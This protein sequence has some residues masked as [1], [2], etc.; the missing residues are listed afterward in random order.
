[1]KQVGT[2]KPYVWDWFYFGR[3]ASNCKCFTWYQELKVGARKMN[4][5]I[6]A[7]NGFPGGLV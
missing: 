3:I 4:D 1:M 2:S 6:R 5:N 7:L